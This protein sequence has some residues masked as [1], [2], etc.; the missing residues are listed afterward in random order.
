MSQHK[1][2]TAEQIME[3]A[4]VFASA[5]ALVDGPFDVD[6]E[7]QLE[8]AEQERD[9][10]AAMIAHALPQPEARAA[11]SHTLEGTVHFMRSTDGK[12]CACCP[13]GQHIFCRGVRW[14]E[15]KTGRPVHFG[16]GPDVF[17]SKHI[18]DHNSNESRRVRLTVEVLPLDAAQHQEAQP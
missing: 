11:Q 17:I 5:W 6:Y 1:I 18:T 13:E 9:L 12:R 16:N 15:Y 8:N 10:L 4:Q 3:Q 2:Y 14:D 7:E